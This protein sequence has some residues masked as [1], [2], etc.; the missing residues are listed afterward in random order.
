MWR[1]H[2]LKMSNL[3]MKLDI[4]KAFDVV[5]W[6]YLLDI[7][8]DL[9]FVCRCHDWFSI[10]FRTSTS[11]TLLNGRQNA[12]FSHIRGIRQATHALHF[13]LVT[14]LGYVSRRDWRLII[15]F[16]LSSS[17]FLF[18]LSSSSSSFLPLPSFSTVFTGAGGWNPLAPLRSATYFGYGWW[19]H[20]NAYLT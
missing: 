17:F 6:G 13:W 16:F 10:I 4:H 19:I 7:L 8:H 15:S 11:I 3:F 18:S 5:N 1:L 2:K 9:G 20:S 14:H 12:C